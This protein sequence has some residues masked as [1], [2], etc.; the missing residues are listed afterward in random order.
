MKVTINIDC[1]PEEARAFLGLPDLKPLHD[2][3][4]DR[5]KHLMTDGV[6]AA[7]MDKLMRQWMPSMTDNFA[8]WQ[9]LFWSAATG[10]KSS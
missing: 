3:Y 1:S 6:T 7:D 9:K 5:M 8:E 2:M 10:Q 4:I